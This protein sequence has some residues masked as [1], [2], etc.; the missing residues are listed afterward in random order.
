MERL[1]LLLQEQE[2]LAPRR[3]VDAYLMPLGEAAELNAQAVAEK[4]RMNYRTCA[5]WCTAAAVQ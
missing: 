2:K 5:S 1:V 4:L 3:A